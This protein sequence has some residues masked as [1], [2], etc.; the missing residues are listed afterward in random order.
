MDPLRGEFSESRTAYSRK[1]I[2]REE[3]VEAVK[4]AVSKLG[5]DV[6]KEDRKKYAKILLDIVEQGKTPREAMGF[7]LEDIAAIYNFA[8]SYYSKGQYK[9]AI[10]LYKMLATLDPTYPNFATSLGVCYHQQ[11]DYE[12][13][14]AAYTLAITYSTRDPI[15]YYYLYDC[16]M[17]INEKLVAGM[18][19]AYAIHEA[20]D[21]E[22]Y[23]KI[24]ERSQKLYAALIEEAEGAASTAAAKPVGEKG[25]P[26]TKKEKVL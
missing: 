20:G 26:L 17:H 14:I 10:E 16:Y 8:Y 21:Q 7:P 11:K 24:K 19:I 23:K 4:K 3:A 1:L 5:G 2:T 22:K 6:S 13:A 9:E 15:P 12:K 25:E 18:M